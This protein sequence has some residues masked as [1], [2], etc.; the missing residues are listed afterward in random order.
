WVALRLGQAAIRSE[1]ALQRIMQKSSTISR[2]VIE[3]RA[4]GRGEP[5]AWWQTA[6]QS[7]E[8]IRKGCAAQCASADG[9]PARPD[10]FKCRSANS[11]HHSRQNGAEGRDQLTGARPVFVSFL[12]ALLVAAILAASLALALAVGLL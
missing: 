12:R 8:N 5:A 4:T 7:P 10:D 11:R 9:V 2:A 1:A 6:G 3:S